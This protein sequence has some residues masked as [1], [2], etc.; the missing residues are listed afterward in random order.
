MRTMNEDKICELADFIKQYARENN[1]ESPSL[2]EITKMM[3]MSK[4]TAYR[5]VLELG[6]RGIVSYSGKNTLGGS[7]QRKMKCGYRKIPLAGQIVCGSPDEQEE[8][9]SGYLAI[10]EEWVDGE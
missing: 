5:Y 10:P 7:Q 4:S 9:I 3:G 2:A 1:G 6:K 8:Y